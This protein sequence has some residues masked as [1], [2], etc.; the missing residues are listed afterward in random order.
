[1][2]DIKKYIENKDQSFLDKVLAGRNISMAS[3]NKITSMI[4]ETLKEYC[5][6]NFSG[7][8]VY[9]IKDKKMNKFLNNEL[10]QD[11]T[12]YETVKIE[13]GKITKIGIDKDNFSSDLCVGNIYIEKNGK[14]IFD[15]CATDDLNNKIIDNVNKIINEQNEILNNYRKEG[16]LY[17]V[18]EEINDARFIYD[19]TDKP[20][21]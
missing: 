6:T 8:C 19:L 5:Q 1:M 17:M 14:Y 9:F 13:S 18:T 11:N 7:E 2:N 15:K 10:V 21:Y 3:E 12:C 20:G 16:H 4:N